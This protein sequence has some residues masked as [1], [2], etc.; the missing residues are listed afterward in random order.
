MLM[1]NWGTLN[2]IEEQN[3]ETIET[4]MRLNP[5]SVFTNLLADVDRYIDNLDFVS[6][7]KPLNISIRLESSDL[8]ASIFEFLCDIIVNEIFYKKVITKERRK[9]REYRLDAPANLLANL[10]CGR[11]VIKGSTNFK[12]NYP[13][14]NIQI[15]SDDFRFNL[16][17]QKDEENG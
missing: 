6:T 4:T 15:S 17:K 5:L 7:S 10:N 9:G 1:V 8:N 11:S 13:I 16:V 14:M 12:V 3:Y 2:T